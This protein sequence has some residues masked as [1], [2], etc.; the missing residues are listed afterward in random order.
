MDYMDRLLDAA[1]PLNARPASSHNS[2]HFFVDAIRDHFTS[3]FVSGEVKWSQRN[4]VDTTL[5]RGEGAP[6]FLYIGGEG[7]QS[8]PSWTLAEEHGALML[9]SST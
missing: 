8:P 1:A 9:S 2:T 5:W 6:V 4:Y 7:P 3:S